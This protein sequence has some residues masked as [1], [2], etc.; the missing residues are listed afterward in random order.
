[1]D[2]LRAAVDAA[3]DKL[4]AGQAKIESY[5]EQISFYETARDQQ[6][7]IATG[8]LEIAEQKVKGE[9]QLL[10]GAKAAALQAQQQYDRYVQLLSQK[11]ASPQEV[12]I[13]TAKRAKAL[14]DVEKYTAELAAA[15]KDVDVKR[16][17][18][19]YARADAEA[20]IVEARTKLQTAEG[21]VA[22]AKDSRLKAERDLARFETQMVTAPRDGIVVRLIANQ[23]A[24]GRQVHAGDPLL[25]F[26]PDYRA[27]AVEL[28]LDGND[29]PWVTPGRNVRLQFEG[30]P[31]LQFT[32]GIP[33][34]SLGTY[35][36]RVLLVDAAPN[37]AGKFRV[38]VE[39]TDDPAEPPWPGVDVD[40]SRDI[41]R[42]LR[43]GVR[44]NGWVL[45]DRVTLGYE[46]W[47][48]LYG[49]P[50]SIEPD[51]HDP[52][53]ASDD[54]GSKSKKKSGKEGDK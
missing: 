34:A 4:E 9:E 49:F 37:A 54:G 35:A 43:Q 22:T 44:V 24:S 46:I 12:E 50:P 45:L 15:R 53:H 29:A 42:E 31:A 13:E 41:R 7:S 38:L 32:A 3:G 14:A 20:K 11:L 21:D 27:R 40:P 19:D 39:P 47:R 1:M 26:V 25:Q 28:W 8:Q 30:W 52:Y 17:Y 36:G 48:Q 10:S 5:S 16:Q 51:R 23:G 33:Q 18:V 6:L 2:R